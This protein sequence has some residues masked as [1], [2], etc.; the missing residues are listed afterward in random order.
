[1]ASRRDLVAEVKTDVAKSPVVGRSTLL[2]TP[3]E[4]NDQGL[5][6]T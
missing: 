4:V 1:M 5:Q 2:P 6:P 3:D